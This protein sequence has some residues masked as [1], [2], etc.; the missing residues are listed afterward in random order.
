MKWRLTGLVSLS[1]SLSYREGGGVLWVEMVLRW[2]NLVVSPMDQ[3]IGWLTT[4][5]CSL[6][7]VCTFAVRSS[8]E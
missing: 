2:K 1:L 7:E 6:L 5:L 3:E 8:L 4:L